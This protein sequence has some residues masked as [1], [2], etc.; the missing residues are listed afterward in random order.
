MLLSSVYSV[1]PNS[2]VNTVYT[3]CPDSV[4]NEL[5][6]STETLLFYPN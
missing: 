5:S 1:C 3:V 6:H 2:I 4:V